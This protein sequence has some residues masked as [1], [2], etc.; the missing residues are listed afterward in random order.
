MIEL[1]QNQNIQSSEYNMYEMC[2]RKENEN[3]IF[4]EDALGDDNDHADKYK[5]QVVSMY[6]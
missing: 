4:R 1:P 2:L 5:P 3:S 6:N